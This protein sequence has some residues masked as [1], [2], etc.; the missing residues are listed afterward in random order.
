MANKHTKHCSVLLAISKMQIKATLKD[1]GDDS[2][3]IKI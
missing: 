1:W 3:C 2:I